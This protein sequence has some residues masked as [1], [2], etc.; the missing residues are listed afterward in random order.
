MI[1]YDICLSVSDTS[2]SMTISGSIHAGADSIISFF[3]WQS[4]IPLYMH[5]IFFIHSSV[6][7]HL[8]G[9]H[10]LATMSSVAMMHP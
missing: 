3:L 6:D 1:S 5:H 7:G 8:G 4:N 10:A 2:L 9:F